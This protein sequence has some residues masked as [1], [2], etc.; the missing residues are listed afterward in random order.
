MMQTLK[1]VMTSLEQYIF[2]KNYMKNAEFRG[3]NY[4][5]I[6][7]NVVLFNDIKDSTQGI[8]IWEKRKKDSCYEP[9][10]LIDFIYREDKELFIVMNNKKAE[11]TMSPEFQII[12]H[13]FTNNEIVTIYKALDYIVEAV[14][15]STKDKDRRLNRI[16]DDKVKEIIH[17]D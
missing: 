7:E 2:L 5:E 1:P 17:E 8:G 3:L 6:T 4:I 14:V 12:N 15:D 16:L 11:F 13:I 10:H 9:D